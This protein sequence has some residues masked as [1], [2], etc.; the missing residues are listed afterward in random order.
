MF[1]LISLN[2]S[3]CGSGLTGP[4]ET[5]FFKCPSCGSNWLLNGKQLVSCTVYIGET[6]AVASE[7]RQKYWL[8]FWYFIAKLPAGNMASFVPAFLTDNLQLYGDI[9]RLLTHEQPEIKFRT[10]DNISN[11]NLVNID[12]SRALKIAQ[13]QLKIELIHK[14]AKNFPEQV[15]NLSCALISLPFVKADSKGKMQL[16]GAKSSFHKC[17]IAG[18]I[19]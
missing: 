17:A 16:I 12:K 9:G 15:E 10:A 11:S 13:V 18:K 6:A 3:N 19:L 4:E 7:Q 5:I 2:C 14:F 8:P 1:E